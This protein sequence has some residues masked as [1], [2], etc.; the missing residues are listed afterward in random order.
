MWMASPPEVHSALLNSGPG[1]G[2]LL[3]AAGS[4][5]A[6][7]AAYTDAAAELGQLVAEVQA[8]VW[9]GPAAE[10]YVSATVRHATW[11]QQAGADSAVLAAQHEAGA[12]AYVTAQAAMPSLAELAANHATHAVLVSTNFFGVNTIPIA[13]NEADYVQMWIRAATTMGSYQAVA[14]AAVT[15]T[16]PA[17]P[18]PQI[19]ASAAPAQDASAGRSANPLQGLLDALEPILKSLGIS[20]SPVAHD[21]MISNPVTTFVAQIL[22]NFGAHWDPAAGTLNGHVYDYYSNAAEPIWYLARSLEL[23]EDFL[24]VTQNPG[25]ALQALQ[26]VA[27]LAL[28]DWPTHVAQFAT[29]LSQSPQL[30]VAAAA[31]TAAP[32]GSV[33]GLGGL[34][35]L[36]GLTGLPQPAAVAVPT[37]PVW[38]GGWPAPAMTAVAA[39]PAAPASAPAPASAAAP[40]A[41]TS[42]TAGFPPAPAGGAGFFPPYLVGPPGT[43]FGSGAS[44]GARSSAERKASESEDAT[45]AAGSRSTS[46]RQP[47]ERR[48]RGAARR[49]DSEQSGQMDVEIEPDW[50]A[51]DDRPTAP[52]AVS[53]QGVGRLGFT[54]TLSRADAQAT[55]LETV[56]DQFGTASRLPLVPGSWPD[57]GCRDAR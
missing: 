17:V 13:L 30:L 54:G 15:A 48:R 32:V 29:A 10:S 20:D 24:Q 6:L 8:G 42:A 40:A 12:A 16:P 39:L 28:F 47:R 21:P 37:A 3:S 7:A 49:G 1:V 33:G 18:A 44:T 31:A 56:A 46:R 14:E 11:L 2:S 53:D 38:S 34:A 4:W 22:Q 52:T 50:V 43:G 51:L 35:G 25:Q 27:A 55:G 57:S 36:A 45:A 26:Y 23:F 9:A 19:L 5:R 41:V